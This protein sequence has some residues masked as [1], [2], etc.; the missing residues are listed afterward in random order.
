MALELTQILL[1][2][3]NMPLKLTYPIG[4]VAYSNFSISHNIPLEV[5]YFV[6]FLYKWKNIEYK[7]NT[8]LH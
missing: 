5:L 4:I 3:K 6:E 1:Y 7:F 8:S 2:Q